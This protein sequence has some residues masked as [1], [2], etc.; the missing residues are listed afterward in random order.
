MSFTLKL[1]WECNYDKK[2]SVFIKQMFRMNSAMD[3]KNEEKE[4]NQIYINK[5]APWFLMLLKL[6]E[7]WKLWFA[8]VFSFFFAFI[9]V[10]FTILLLL[11]LF[12]WIQI[13][14]KDIFLLIR[15]TVYSDNNNQMEKILPHSECELH[16]ELDELFST[17]HILF[18]F[19]MLE[20]MKCVLLEKK[21]NQRKKTQYLLFQY[22]IEH[23]MV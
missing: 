3:G 9:S 1:Y 20:T 19:Q 23:W 14:Q 5:C 21:M 17:F 13:I 16:Y 6:N 10:L 4:W 15:C 22:T 12:P 11:I 18:R 8:L 7:W 2:I